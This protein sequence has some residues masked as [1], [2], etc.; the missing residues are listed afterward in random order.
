MMAVPGI[1]IVCRMFPSSLALVAQ[2]STP[3]VSSA[4]HF[5]NRADFVLPPSSAGA[6]IRCRFIDACSSCRS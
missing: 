3:G 2:V 5:R 6:A 1:S 4:I